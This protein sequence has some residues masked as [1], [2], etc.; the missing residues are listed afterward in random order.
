[1]CCLSCLVFLSFLSPSR[2]LLCPDLPQVSEEVRLTL[3]EFMHA[4]SEQCTH[5]AQLTPHLPELMA[6]VGRV[7]HDP[8]HEVRKV[9]A[10]MMVLLADRHPQH[11]QLHAP[12]L[13]RALLPSLSHQHAKMRGVSLTALRAVSCC[14]EAPLI[15]YDCS[16]VLKVVHALCKDRACAV[17]EQLV[18][19]LAQWLQLRASRGGGGEH[20]ATQL[21]TAT[22]VLVGDENSTVN[23]AAYHLLCEAGE[24]FLRAQPA[25]PPTQPPEDLARVASTAQAELA[26]KRGSTRNQPSAPSLH[27]TT[28]PAPRCPQG[29]PCYPAPFSAR[30]PNGAVALVQAHLK[31]ILPAALSE[32]SEWTEAGQCSA[33]QLLH[34][35]LLLCEDEALSMLPQ[36]L[37]ALSKARTG[38]STKAMQAAVE[39]CA[40]VC[41]V[42]APPE[43]SIPVLIPVLPSEPGALQV[44]TELLRSWHGP[45]PPQ[46]VLST[47]V[48]SMVKLIHTQELNPQRIAALLSLSEAAA[49]TGT[50]S[51]PQL[52]LIFSQLAVLSECT[53]VDD[54]EELQQRCAVAEL[55][56]AGA[57][58]VERLYGE[59]AAY[60]LEELTAGGL[61]GWTGSTLAWKVFR[62]VVI[63]AG[64]PM[65]A[66]QAL[67]RST[68]LSCLHPAREPGL[69]VAALQL[70]LQLT[71]SGG[72][73]PWDAAW[74]RELMLEGVLPNAMWRAGKGAALVRQH[75]LQVLHR[76]AQRCEQSHKQHWGEAVRDVS[77]GLLAMLLSALEDDDGGSR[78]L[79]AQLLQHVLCELPPDTLTYDQ[80][81]TMIPEVLKRMD[82]SRD[83]VRLAALEAVHGMAAVIESLQVGVYTEYIT[84]GLLIYIDDS[85]MKE[86]VVR[87]LARFARADPDVFC[88]EVNKSIQRGV[89]VEACGELLRV[90]EQHRGGQ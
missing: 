39:R 14:G 18:A 71:C 41:G 81:R 10:S 62:L 67:A 34:T 84:A 29:L 66:Q 58:G 76:L 45:A 64:A 61:D 40:A 27:C 85:T 16:E 42:F 82:D 35:V 23:E 4:L 5:P 38:S 47:L 63:R 6:L 68:V 30:P 1:M 89:G 26:A 25:A 3:C 13:V 57:A 48:Q 54:R 70:V 49:A 44:C 50:A 17:R 79:A 65:L 33:V 19:A 31:L 43:V 52:V 77:H 69:R 73:L 80:V 24:G 7:C 46:R 60:V 11:T 55:S 59:H 9:G 8:F 87:T 22:M 51:L 83:V 32:L 15:L 88:K 37:V 53:P 75:A 78:L 28:P 20:V 74:M 90:A 36:L 21:L 72:Q 86:A 2:S 12:A 56:L